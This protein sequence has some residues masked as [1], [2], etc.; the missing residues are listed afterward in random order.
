MGCGALMCVLASSVTLR[1]LTSSDLHTRFFIYQDRK[2]SSDSYLFRKKKTVVGRQEILTCTIQ[3]LRGRLPTS[4]NS[5]CLGP[6]V[7][8]ARSH[9][10]QFVY[11]YLPHCNLNTG[12][13]GVLT[14]PSPSTSPRN[15]LVSNSTVLHGS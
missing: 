9:G 13:S 4:Q 2:F 7:C 1:G 10:H 12:M 15:S 11:L 6:G 3:A 5:V 14:A 8:K